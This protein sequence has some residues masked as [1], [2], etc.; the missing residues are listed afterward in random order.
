MSSPTISIIVPVYNASLY[1]GQ[2]LDSILA[3][4]FRDFEVI[5]VNDGSTDNS[6][7]IC[8]SYAKKDSRFLIIDKP[9]SGVSDSRNKALDLARGRFLQFMDSDDWLTPDASAVLLHAAESTGSDLV[10]AHFYRVAGGRAAKRGHIKENRVLTRTDYAEEMLKAPAN[11]Y[12][13]VLWNKLY[14]RSII[15]GNRLSFDPQI[16]WSEDFLFN[17]EYLE[18]VRLISAV[19]LPVYYY[20]KREDSLVNSQAN[21]R[22]LAAMKRSTFAEYK[23]L[24]QKLDLYEEKK[25]EVY[26]YLLSAAADGAVGPL[27]PKLPDSSI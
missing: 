3:Q 17:L 4:T 16:K 12:Y 13:G 26:R 24:Y 9:N 7:N 6:L 20:R 19:S 5:L 10:I 22:K 8:R 11:Y 21:L 25:A 18:H 15:E 23:E 1:L 2:C 27:S 14:R